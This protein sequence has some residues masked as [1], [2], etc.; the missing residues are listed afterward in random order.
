MQIDKSNLTTAINLLSNLYPGL[1]HPK[2]ENVTKQRDWDDAVSK[3]EFLNLHNSAHQVDSARLL[4]A[5]S[6]H[7][8]AWLQA[9]PLPQLGLHLDND[10]A[11]IAVALRLGAQICEPHRCRCGQKVDSS[12]HHGLACQKSA[13]RCPRHS[14]VNDIV[15]RGLVTAGIPAMLEP[16]GLDRGNGKCPDGITVFPFSQGKSL[17]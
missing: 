5:A 15:K 16:V 3:S 11:R 6:P 7:T 13:G 8:G 4:A 10:S 17:C 2:G 9:L 14:A 1:E 12:G